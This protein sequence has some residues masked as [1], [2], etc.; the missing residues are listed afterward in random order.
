M[1]RLKVEL[2]LD[3]PANTMQ[4]FIDDMLIGQIS[5]FELEVAEGD[6]HHAFRLA[7]DRFNIDPSERSHVDAQIDH[8][9]EPLR[10]LSQRSAAGELEGD[11]LIEL[12][13]MF[14]S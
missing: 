8:A 9:L 6:P 7:M 4:I 13:E 2:D 5:R 14:F 1:A 12:N 3:D 11:T 10:K